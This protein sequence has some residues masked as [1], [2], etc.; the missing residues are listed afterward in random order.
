M[1]GGEEVSGGL[2]VTSGDRAVLFEFGE[3]VLDQVTS[4]VEGSIELPLLLPIGLRWDHHLLSRGGHRLDDTFIG[5]VGFV[6]DQRVSFEVGQEFIGADE[7]MDLAAGQIKA[8]W[9][10]QRIDPRVNLGAQSAARAPDRLV[11][12]VFFWAPALC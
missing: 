8:G 5:V 2:V 4:G 10:T 6:G 1:H 7:I 9:I 12:P 11:F 3:E